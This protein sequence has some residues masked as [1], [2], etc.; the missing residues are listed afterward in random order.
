MPVASL[1]TTES[2]W[3]P[4]ATVVVSH[5]IEYEGLL[6]HFGTNV[7]AIHPKLNARHADSAAAVNG[8]RTGNCARHRRPAGR[9][10][11]HIGEHQV[12]TPAARCGKCESQSPHFWCRP[13]C[14]WL[15]DIS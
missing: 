12:F 5:L 9:S 10:R 7:R 1:A 11:Y 4:L 14:Q 8:G 15:A 3:S 2:V 13:H 6:L